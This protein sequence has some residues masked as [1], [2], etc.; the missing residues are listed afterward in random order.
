MT[1]P[2]ILTRRMESRVARASSPQSAL[3]QFGRWSAE[4]G[5]GS[6]EDAKARR[7]E[8]RGD[9][10]SF[11]NGGA[12]FVVTWGF[13]THKDAGE[14]H[15]EA[16]RGSGFQP[17]VIFGDHTESITRRRGERGGR[18]AE[19]GRWSSEDGKISPN[20]MERILRYIVGVGEFDKTTIN[21]KLN[22]LKTPAIKDNAMT[23]AE[24]YRQEGRQE[25]LQKGLHE[26]R[27]EGQKEGRREGQQIGQLIGRIQLLQDLLGRDATPAE[28]LASR[29]I[30]DLQAMHDS[31]RASLP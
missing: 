4:V 18:K 16:Q 1:G 31:L 3:G 20:H 30:S 21:R 14:F 15:A 23:I 12:R 26:G 19:C 25:G 9:R 29:S 5:E 28:N 10:T 8:Q 22:T 24:Q 11:T 7:K 6:R 2:E 27:Q 17:A 13:A